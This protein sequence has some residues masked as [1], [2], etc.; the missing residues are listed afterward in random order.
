MTYTKQQ[1]LRFGKI[2]PLA[3]LFFLVLALSSCTVITPTPPSPDISTPSPTQEVVK[4]TVTT[5]P[6][7][8]TIVLEEADLQQSAQDALAQQNEKILSNISFDLQP[9]KMVLHGRAK[10]GWLPSRF[11]VTAILPAVKG[12]PEPKIMFVKW[13]RGGL[14]TPHAV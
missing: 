10:L 1:P 13:R 4:P 7:K 3:A 8:V 9:G 14:F 11:E 5:T 12:K 2:L 6:A